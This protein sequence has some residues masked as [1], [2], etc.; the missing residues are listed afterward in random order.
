M[1]KSWLNEAE[2]AKYLGISVYDFRDIGPQASSVDG[3]G[4]LMWSIRD[5]NSW[6]DKYGDKGTERIRL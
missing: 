3:K 6:D 2:A 4:Q 5:L 1:Q